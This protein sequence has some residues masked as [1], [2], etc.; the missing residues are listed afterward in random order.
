MTTPH[1][2]LALLQLRFPLFPLSSPIPLPLLAGS[3]SDDDEDGE[4]WRLIKN[5]FI[6]LPS[7]VATV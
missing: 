7:N 3:F 2:N 5:L 4:D 6:F 1:E